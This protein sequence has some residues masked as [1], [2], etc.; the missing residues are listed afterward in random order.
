MKLAELL[1]E[2]VRTYGKAIVAM[3]YPAV[4]AYSA[5]TPNGVT[6]VE[7]AVIAI[8][9]L[10]A[11]GLVAVTPNRLTLEQVN[12]FF[13]QTEDKYRGHFEWFDEPSVDA[14]ELAD[15]PDEPPDGSEGRHRRE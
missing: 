13:D 15:N 8:T 2:K 14:Q 5:S 11:A 4:L 1:P 10:S 9:A 6:L 3:V 7:W 12:R